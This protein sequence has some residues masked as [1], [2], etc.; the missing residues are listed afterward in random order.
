MSA[1][2]AGADSISVLPFDNA[3][4]EADE[5]GYRIAR[6][7]Q[8]LLKEESYLEKIVDPAAGSYYIENLTDQIARGAWEHFLKVEELGGYCKALRAGYVQE[9]V[10]KT[11]LSAPEAGK[12]LEGQQI[13]KTVVVP[14]RIINIV[15]KPA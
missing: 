12:Y 13:V 6:N 3:Y 15:I 5:F 2:V 10:E 7:Q 8:L 4:K 14:G 11:A 1:A 9:E